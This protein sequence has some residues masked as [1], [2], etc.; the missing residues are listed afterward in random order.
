MSSI[1]LVYP[2][3]FQVWLCTV[4]F[5][6]VHLVLWC[7]WRRHPAPGM[8][9]PKTIPIFSL[10]G[11]FT[12]SWPLVFLPEFWKHLYFHGSCPFSS[13]LTAF[14]SSH[15]FWRIQSNSTWNSSQ[16]S[17]NCCLA[18]QLQNSITIF[19]SSLL[20]IWLSPLILPF[21]LLNY[22]FYCISVTYSFL[23]MLKEWLISFFLSVDGILYFY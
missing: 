3:H 20:I 10:L 6:K 9:S 15:T 5:Y 14:C 23:L 19:L 7:W 12:C 17:L 1:P 8:C 13:S 2:A 18:F 16:H 11:L 22:L 21:F 4:V